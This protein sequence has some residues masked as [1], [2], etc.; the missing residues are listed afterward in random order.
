LSGLPSGCILRI[1]DL[2]DEMQ[3]NLKTNPSLL[4]AL[5]RS[6]ERTPTSAEIEEQRVSFIMG[7]LKTTNNITR[8]EVQEI[9]AQQGG[10]RIS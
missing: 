3:Q 7:A 5:K 9:L 8:S 2:E 10:K 4:E 1:G 6:A